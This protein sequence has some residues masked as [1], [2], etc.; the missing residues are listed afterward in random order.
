MSL[1]FSFVCLLSSSLFFLSCNLNKSEEGSDKSEEIGKAATQYC[2][3]ISKQTD[4]LSSKLKKAIIRASK[5]DD[6]ET[7]LKE[8]LEKNDLTQE[9]KESIDTDEAD[10]C[11]KKAAKKYELD[12]EDKKVQEKVLAKIEDED[13]CEI[14]A[15]FLRMGLKKGKA[16]KPAT[17]DPVEP[18]T[19]ADEAEKA[20]NELCDCLSGKFP[21]PSDDLKA[22]MKKVGRSEDPA[23]TYRAEL[24]KFED[25]AKTKLDEELNKLA[26]IDNDAMRDCSGKISTYKILGKDPEQRSK[27]ILGIM[28][29]K[30]G[31]DVASGQWAMGVQ[32]TY[33][34]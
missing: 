7:A 10:N 1:K 33:K 19:T 18:T 23:K 34:K 27:R 30:D 28:A 8:E 4:K 12:V 29:A 25:E 13:D 6:P 32:Q 5:E 15:A 2:D 11:A 17:D 24:N 31:C 26:Q 9:F 16:K 22:L 20:A 14:S 3:C 21:D